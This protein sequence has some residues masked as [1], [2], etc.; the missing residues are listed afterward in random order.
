M[1]P[2]PSAKP[3]RLGPVSISPPELLLKA[4][5]DGHRVGLQLVSVPGLQRPLAD[6]GGWWCS[7]RRMWMLNAAT[8]ERVQEVLEHAY[9]G[10]FV[11]LA[12]VDVTLRSALA[13]VQPDYFTQLLDV[14]IFPLAKGDLARGRWAVSFQYDPLCVQAMR[15]LGG[16]FHKHA[17]AWQVRADPQQIQQRLLSIAGIKPEFIF[18]HEQPVVLEQLSDS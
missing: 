11:D 1:N 8:P 9:A 10:Q 6:Y 3:V 16:Y 2:I 17:S 7:A 18:T 14:Q 15:S 12:E 4:C 13:A 5:S